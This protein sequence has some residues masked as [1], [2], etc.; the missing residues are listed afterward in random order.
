VLDGGHLM[1]CLLEWVKGS[2]VSD[3]AQLMGQKIGIAL[4]LA[5]MTLAFFND[6]SRLLD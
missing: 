4:L 2:P 6:L 3:G 5:L 1:Y